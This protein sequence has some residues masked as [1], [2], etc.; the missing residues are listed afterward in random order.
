MARDARLQVR[1]LR[2]VSRGKV[3]STAVASRRPETVV[4]VTMEA[5]VDTE[6]HPGRGCTA[7]VA[8]DDDRAGDPNRGH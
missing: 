3:R 8:A 1:N 2:R 6:I 5:S 7:L 4:T